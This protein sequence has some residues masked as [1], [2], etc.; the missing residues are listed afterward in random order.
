MVSPVS[1]GAAHTGERDEGDP[2]AWVVCAQCRADCLPRDGSR[3]KPFFITSCSHTVCSD[4]LGPAHAPDAIVP[5]PRCGVRCRT[6]LLDTGSPEM[7][8]IKHC[9]RAPRELAE[10]LAAGPSRAD[11][12]MDGAS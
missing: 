11:R 5:C 12:T 2:L 7:A 1:D 4:C 3:S 6:L 10:E 8:S 9:F